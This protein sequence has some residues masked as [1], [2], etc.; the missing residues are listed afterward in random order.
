MLLKW[1]CCWHQHL[2]QYSGAA[3]YGSRWSVAA[4]P[5]SPASLR[6][7][8]WLEAPMHTIAAPE[9]VPAFTDGLTVMFTLLERRLHPPAYLTG[10]VRSYCYR[11]PITCCSP[12]QQWYRARWRLQIAIAVAAECMVAVPMQTGEVPLMVLARKAER[13]MILFGWNRFRRVS[14]LLSV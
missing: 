6:C 5:G 7:Y 1:C 4:A 8:S 2:L 3:V 10:S 11:N 13:W 9:T 14:A 12:C